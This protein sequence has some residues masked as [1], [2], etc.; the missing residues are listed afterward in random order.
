MSFQQSHRVNEKQESVDC[1]ILCWWLKVSL[2]TANIH[3]LAWNVT[4]RPMLRYSDDC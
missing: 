1:D 3:I 2:L 4:D